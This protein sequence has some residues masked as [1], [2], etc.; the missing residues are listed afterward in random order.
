MMPIIPR[1][2][3]FEILSGLEGKVALY[4]EDLEVD[5]LFTVC[6]DEVH[7]ACSLVKVPILALLLKDAE[8]GRINLDEKI[9]I[10]AEKKVGG[11]GLISHLDPHLDLS[12][13]DI[14]KLMIIVSDNTATNA[15]IEILG[16]EKINSFFK[17]IGLDATKLQRKM[18]DFDSIKAGKNNYTSAADMGK[19]LKN[20]ASGTLVNPKISETVLEIM[21]R[22]FYTGKLPALLPTVPAYASPEEK[23]HP[24]TGLVTVANKTGDLPKIQHDIGFFILP[25]GKKYVIAMLTSDLSSDQEGIACISKVSRAVYDALSQE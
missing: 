7:A 8:E 18:M 11:T 15:I 22:Q 23:K 5:E 21:S 10:A 13:K 3:I 20:A 17:S 14:M 12:W 1:Q 24:L 16:L 25:G 2:K 6:P 9:R 4:V 19:L